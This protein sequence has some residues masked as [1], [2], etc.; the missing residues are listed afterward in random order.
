M[1][2]QERVLNELTGRIEHVENLEV[3]TRTEWA[4]TGRL[5]V[6]EKDTVFVHCTIF[7]TFDSGCCTFRF[8]PLG[9]ETIEF[10]PENRNHYA[11]AVYN[12]AGAIELAISK[13]YELAVDAAYN[14]RAL[15]DQLLD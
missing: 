12:K 6:V 15:R 8:M 10:V 3:L 1:D 7:Y 14:N 5:L 9:Q 2:V 4:N 13:M 11:R